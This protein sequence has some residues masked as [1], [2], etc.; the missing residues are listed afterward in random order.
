M[1]N[2]IR[3]PL[4]T[5]AMGRLVRLNTNSKPV[6][7]EIMV[8]NHQNNELIR[9]IHRPFKWY[10]AKPFQINTWNKISR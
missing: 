2:R 7:W 10:A 1:I 9:F 5:G 8:I 3:L 4:F 6:D